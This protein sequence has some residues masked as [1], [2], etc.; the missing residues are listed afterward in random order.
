MPD[1]NMIEPMPPTPSSVGPGRGAWVPSTGP[2]AGAAVFSDQGPA[3]PTVPMEGRVDERGG[4][5]QA[6]DRNSEVVAPRPQGFALSLAPVRI[7][8]PVAVGNRPTGNTP[9]KPNRIWA[10][11]VA[12]LAENKDAE[13]FAG[14][15]RKEGYKAYVLTS[16]V[17]E[18]IWHRVRV[19]QFVNQQEAQELKKALAASKEYRHAYVAV[20]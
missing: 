14:K 2:S 16:Q 15:M 10:V 1:P 9:V 6:P 4:S 13:S 11:Q 19:G 3:R 17:A 5:L 20:N 18:K 7:E 8:P 12:A